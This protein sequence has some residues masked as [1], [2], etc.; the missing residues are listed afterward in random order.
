[1]LGVYVVVL[2]PATV[3]DREFLTEGKKKTVAKGKMM[4]GTINIRED[5]C[6]L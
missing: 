3:F 6:R 4:T 5:S 2:G 1:V